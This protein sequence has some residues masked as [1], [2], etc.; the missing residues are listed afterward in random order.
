M[1][2]VGS[3]EF[4]RIGD[5]VMAMPEFDTVMNNLEEVGID[6]KKLLKMIMDFFGW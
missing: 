3:K 5:V 1:K 2:T 6:S 4:R